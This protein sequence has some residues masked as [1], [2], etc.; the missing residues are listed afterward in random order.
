MLE[1]FLLNGPG[2]SSFLSFSLQ[3]SKCKM[4]RIGSFGKRIASVFGLPPPYSPPLP[5]P[6]LPL[7]PIQQAVQLLLF[8]PLHLLLPSPPPPRKQQLA[9]PPSA[10]RPPLLSPSPFLPSCPFPCTTAST[11][12]KSLPHGAATPWGVVIPT[13]PP[14]SPFLPSCEAR[15]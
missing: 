7:P 4:K 6:L 9:P 15:H 8:L 11:S 3:F 1:V 12:S 10:P 2:C 13:P 14:F 5:P